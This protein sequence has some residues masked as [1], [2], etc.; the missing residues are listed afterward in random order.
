MKSCAMSRTKE[1]TIS[2][3][4]GVFPSF[5]SAGFSFFGYGN[6]HAVHIIKVAVHI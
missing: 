4:T 1:T 2:T 6:A 5:H 3:G